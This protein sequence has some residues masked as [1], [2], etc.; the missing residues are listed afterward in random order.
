MKVALKLI[1]I[2]VKIVKVGYIVN[3]NNSIGKI[4]EINNGVC[5]ILFPDGTESDISVDEAKTHV[6]KFLVQTSDLRTY[7][8]VHSD[9]ED[10][11]YAIHKTGEMEKFIKRGG[12]C[13]GRFTNVSMMPNIDDLIEIINIDIAEKYKLTDRQKRIGVIS[14]VNSKFKFTAKFG[15]QDIK[16]VRNDFKI[17]SGENAKQVFN[18]IF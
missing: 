11:M 4:A 5:C 12:H 14:K 16:L 10:L 6:A 15:T 9:F 18:V 3:V 7:P 17:I 13:E 2:D 1:C 8:V